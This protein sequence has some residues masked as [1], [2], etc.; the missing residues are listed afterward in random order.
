MGKNKLT[1]EEL[2]QRVEE[3]ETEFV[4]LAAARED[5]RESEE[6]FRKIADSAHEAIIMLNNNGNISYWNEAAEKIFGYSKNEVQNKNLCTLLI[7]ERYRKDHQEGF[8]RFKE[9]GEGTLIGKTLALSALKKGGEEFPIEL[10]VSAVKLKGKWNAI[11]IV[12]DIT[13]RKRAEEQL[14]KLH[15]AVE[16]SP[17]SIVITD[18]EGNIEYVNPKFAQ[19]TGYTPQEVLGENLRILKSGHQPPELYKQLWNKISS[20]KVW[21]GEFHNRKKNGEFYWESAS[22][23]PIINAKGMITHFVGV[24]ED[25][26]ERKQAEEALKARQ[27]EI[28][29][30]NATLEQRVHEE[31]EK[32][33]QKD[34]IMMHQSRL[35]AMGEMIGNI[36][37]QWKQPLNALNIL[38]Y[39]I[40]EFF[41]ESEQDQRQLDDFI[42][43]GNEL[44]MKMAATVDDFR[45]F[46]KPNKEKEEFSVNE[47]IKVS[48]SL[49]DDSIKYDEISVTLHAKEELIV[50]GFPN[51]FSQVILNILTNAKDAI[52]ARGT[53]G[54]IGIDVIRD[55]NTCVVKV[56]DNGGGIPEDILENIFDPYY[57]TKE[58][59]KGTGIG[60][61]MCKTIVE[62]HMNGCI[63][64]QNTHGGAE[65]KIK[66]PL[67]ASK[68]KNKKS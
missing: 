5:L 58:E 64:V 65:F 57:T 46:F 24:K 10:S 21:R 29:N 9:R 8:T 56:K 31:V 14:R 3:L 37:H 7:P 23:S 25:V 34:F 62:D 13:E 2:E 38:L 19:I 11:G 50:L 45:Y 59:T 51:E 32:S 42:E 12:K 44:V 63:E 22:I 68:L 30:L 15:R 60:L 28:E 1:Y 16:Q 26:T 17:V 35:A 41:N 6:K 27:K 67:I 54:K 48:L 33:L 47:I 53:S 43:K 36:A 52:T 40:K 49:V 66:I 4:E 18:Y 39:N 20:G 55:N 61:Y